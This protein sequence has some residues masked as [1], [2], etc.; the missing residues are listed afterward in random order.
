MFIAY[1]VAQSPEV[2]PPPPVVE[3]RS[4]EGSSAPTGSA[5]ALEFL[6]NWPPRMPPYVSVEALIGPRFGQT[7]TLFPA[8]PGAASPDL[9][10]P[11]V[12]NLTGDGGSFGGYAKANL[13]I[14][15][16]APAIGVDF[17]F[18]GA[19]RNQVFTSPPSSD[20]VNPGGISE[21]LPTRTLGIHGQILGFGLGYRSLGFANGL[22]GLG[23]ERSANMIANNIGLGI[24]L[25]PVEA[26]CSGTW[27]FGWVA[28]GGTAMVLPADGEA[29][30]GLSVWGLKLAVGVQGEM[31]AYG[32]NL[33]ALFSSFN[34]T[35][36]TSGALQDVSSTVAAQEI[37]KLGRMSYTWGP[38]VQAGISF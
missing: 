11:R 38:Y 31:L 17:N 16:L 18:R 22:P 26:V 14:P 10:S 4:Q 27:G 6:K 20:A 9:G 7:T 34:P 8:F 28:D 25:G 24:P 5:P 19:S 12:G 29:H 33:G 15:L 23:G 35:S 13:R 32:G 37:Q 2:P 21:V 1:P 36:L 3:E 30:L